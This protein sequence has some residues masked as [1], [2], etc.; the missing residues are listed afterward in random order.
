MISLCLTIR[1]ISATIKELM[2]TNAVNSSQ[3][4]ISILWLTLFADQRVISIVGVV[5]VAGGSTATV[6]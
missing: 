1:F 3:E 5:G 2:H 6:W 4:M